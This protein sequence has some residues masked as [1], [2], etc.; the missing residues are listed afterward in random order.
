MKFG[1]TISV[2]ITF[3]SANVAS[4]SE[5]LQAF[6]NTIKQEC[7]ILLDREFSRYRLHID[8]YGAESYG[9]AFAKGKLRRNSGLRAP[10]SSMICIY[11][12]RSR[13][14]EISQ[15]FDS[16]RLN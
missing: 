7:S 10:D 4:A 15:S 11:D 2:L 6:E 3:L 12:K 14:A 5:E 16:E 1:L 9:I 13:R 8:P